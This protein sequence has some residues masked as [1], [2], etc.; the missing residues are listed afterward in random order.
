[1]R[2]FIAVSPDPAALQLISALLPPGRASDP[3]VRWTP[4]ANLHLTLLFL[5][6]TPD[7]QVSGMAE[8]MRRA[9][10][11][12]AG[13]TVLFDRKGDFRSAGGRVLWLGASETGPLDGL[14]H[15]IRAAFPDFADTRPFQAHLTVG[16]SREKH[17]PAAFAALEFS[18]VPFR[19]SGVRLIRS[20]L[21]SAGADYTVL[22]E[23]RLV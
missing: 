22:D 13:F 20:V 17:T 6:E 15:A 12:L 8:R 11:G 23:V 7:D 5:G 1:M 2:L 9:V 14:A 18:P 10:A 19:V 3:R 4:P 21:S 16:R